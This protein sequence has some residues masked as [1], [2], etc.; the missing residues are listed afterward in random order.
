MTVPVRTTGPGPRTRQSGPGPVADVAPGAILMAVL[1]VAVVHIALPRA[2]SWS[3]GRR[4]LTAPPGRTPIR[5]TRR[6]ERKP[7]P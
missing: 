6:S 3:T 1:D 4:P 7:T 5:Y 2:Q